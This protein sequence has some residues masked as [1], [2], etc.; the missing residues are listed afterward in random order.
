MN[1]NTYVKSNSL[2]QATV[3]NLTT[4]QNHF[5][6]MLL[7]EYVNNFDNSSIEDTITMSRYDIMN[8]LGLSVSGKTYENINKSIETFYRNS[9]I[10]WIDDNK[11]SRTTMALFSKA[12]ITD[13]D[14]NKDSN[15]VFKWNPEFKPYISNLKKEYT[16]L[17]TSN[18]LSLK[19][20]KSQTLY[21]FFHSYISQGFVTV[22]VDKLRE[23]TECP[24]S[25]YK[26]FSDFMKRGITGPINEI[27]D[28][29]DIKVE[30]ISKNKGSI[31]KK[32]I[33]SI[34]FKVS[35]Q[36]AKKV[37]FENCPNILLTEDEY[38][39]ITQEFTING[40][41]VGKK[42]VYKL[43]E[44]KKKKPGVIH[45]DFKQIEKYYKADLKKVEKNT[46]PDF[47]NLDF[48]YTNM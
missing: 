45:N 37:W 47:E 20:K 36:Q 2:V 18:F 35:N 41:S 32:V 19:S 23:L 30:V 22:Y 33:V 44:T 46:K 28:K 5:M 42:Y 40:V 21:E 7:T 10:T 29:T 34:T 38:R 14:S 24:I 9:I 15:V 1:K 8:Y 11:K 13:Y 31:N 39:K 25:S 27:N 3:N 26:K 6:A 43:S 17:I 16:V 48:L 4:Q 12:E